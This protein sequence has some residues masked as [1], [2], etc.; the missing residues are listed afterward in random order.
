MTFR[1]FWVDPYQSRLTT[2]IAT[3]AGDRVTLEST[4]FFALSGGQESDAG[5]ISGAPVLAAAKQGPEIFYTLPE[6]H[7]LAPGQEVEVAIDWTRRYRLMRLHFAA[8]IVLELFLRVLAG[9]E[10]IG[11]HI[12]QD[13]SRID[14][15]WPESISPLLAQIAAQA[16]AIVAADFEIRTGF[17]DEANQRRFWEIDG[18]SRVSCGGTHVKRTGEIGQIRLKRNNIGKGKERVEIYLDESRSIASG[19]G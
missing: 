6:Q 2:R 11:S 18:F 12:A 9:V 13:K 5:T 14:F 3:V 4:I 7:G 1:Q 19:Q 16:N 17:D 8:E 10:R 15:A